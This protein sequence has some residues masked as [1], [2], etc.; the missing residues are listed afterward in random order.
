MFTPCWRVSRSSASMRASSVR[1]IASGI[2]FVPRMKMRRLL[3]QNWR[4]PSFPDWSLYA[5]R[6][7]KRRRTTCSPWAVFA[8]QT[9][10][11]SSGRPLFTGHQRRGLASV[12]LKCSSRR[13]PRCSVTSCVN[14]RGV[15][16]TSISSV[17]FALPR[18]SQRSQFEL[19]ASTEMSSSADFRSSDSFVRTNGASR[20]TSPVAKNTMSFQMPVLRSRMPSRNVKSHPMLISIV[21][22]RPISPSPPLAYSIIPFVLHWRVSP[23]MSSG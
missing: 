1:S 19:I 20:R 6:T 16:S 18:N 9:S 4:A 23:G 11:Y 14:R 2:Q 3:I 21:T 22:L 15:P 10:V 7:P 12:P 5:S 17:P 8:R 13:S